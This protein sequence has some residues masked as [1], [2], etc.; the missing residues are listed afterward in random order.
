[1][2]ERKET[3]AECQLDAK[4]F[5]ELLRELTHDQ[6]REI[7]GVM[8]GMKMA[9]TPEKEEAKEKDGKRPA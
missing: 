2:E 5:A 1:M 7:R 6:K 9:T 3:V 8:I 4:E